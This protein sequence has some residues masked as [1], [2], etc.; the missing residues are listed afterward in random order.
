[1]VQLLSD[2]GPEKRSELE[3]GIDEYD[4][5]SIQSRFQ[6]LLDQ[7]DGMQIVERLAQ[8]CSIYLF[9]SFI[10]ICLARALTDSERSA[11]WKARQEAKLAEEMQWQEED[12]RS[13][14]CE[15]LV[16]F[17]GVKE[18]SY[19]NAVAIISPPDRLL[20]RRLHNLPR[21]LLEMVKEAFFEPPQ[22]IDLEADDAAV[23]YQSSRAL[24][25]ASYAEYRE[26][27]ATE[28]VW[29]IPAGTCEEALSF[30]H[31]AP[32]LRELKAEIRN[33]HLVLSGSDGFDRER[34]MKYYLTPDL[35]DDPSYR[36]SIPSVLE[37]F[38]SE[39]ARAKMETW[40]EWDMK[41]SEA[42]SVAK[43][44]LLVEVVDNRTLE[45]D[46]MTN[47]VDIP[48]DWDW[49]WMD[50]IG[51]LD[52]LDDYYNYYG[53]YGSEYVEDGEDGATVETIV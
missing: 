17:I 51:D 7:P 42:R 21:E 28:S 20:R 53:Y 9:R 3:A 48:M 2:I 18:N 30:F 52:D 49:D 44:Y 13:R 46:R 12:E 5:A 50:L 34:L 26:S 6:M 33:V 14:I 43:D 15:E 19:W 35:P 11:M 24:K 31:W 4:F 45:G 47:F 23:A 38:D 8:P 37:R 36:E 25:K 10:R 27:L 29:K 40:R 39:C 32:G 22:T 16:P 41:A 1:M